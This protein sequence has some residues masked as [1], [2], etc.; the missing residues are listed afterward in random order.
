MNY[1]YGLLRKIWH[2]LPLNIRM[3][4]SKVIWNYYK[5]FRLLT[6]PKPINIEYNNRKRFY[7]IGF[8]GTN[9]SH[10]TASDLLVLEFE[11]KGFDY[12]KLDIS[13][14]HLQTKKHID[15]DIIADAKLGDNIVFAVNPD[16]LPM[17]YRAF[18]KSFF[19]NKYL[20]GYWVYEL[21]KLP[22]QWQIALT[23]INEL[24]VPSSFVKK[25]IQQYSDI[26]IKIVPHAVGLMKIDLAQYDRGKIR[27][28]LAIEDNVFIA[29]T[30]F[31]FSSS[32]ERKNIIGT[33][34]AFEM[35]F[36]TSKKCLLLIRYINQKNF[37]ESLQKLEQ[38]VANSSS[39]IKLLDEN[40]LGGGVEAL[41]KLYTASDVLLSL[42]RSEGFGLQIAEAMLFKLPVI[43]NNYSAPYDF[44]NDDN[45]LL[46]KYKLIPA[47]DPDNVYQLK[48]TF[49]AD[50]DLDDASKYLQLLRHNPQ[51]AKN[52]VDRAADEVKQHLSGCPLF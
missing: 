40:A 4:L 41:F 15:V 32:M 27:K 14:I 8:F 29:L 34:K 7:I 21:D 24:W 6:M 43:T 10:K 38:F 18:P 52:I 26:K 25:T 48:D 35:A 39:N 23:K 13:D 28:E 1:I 12:I 9:L 37:P 36:G 42:H 17:I 3:S 47:N 20:I 46:V 44:V 33:I 50:A 5:L 2:L 49:W 11:K 16:I 30:S 31:S 45:S 22:I 19:K 51:M